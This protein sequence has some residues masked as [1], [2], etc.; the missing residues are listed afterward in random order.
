M[1]TTVVDRKGRVII[2]SRI[3]RNLKLRH[4]DTMLVETKDEGIM[5][6]VQ[7]ANTQRDV[8]FQDFRKAAH[9]DHS[10]ATRKYLEKL[11]EEHWAGSS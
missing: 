10:L 5:L 3:R 7:T 11:E 6:R 1:S 2:P 4:G 8:M 9:S